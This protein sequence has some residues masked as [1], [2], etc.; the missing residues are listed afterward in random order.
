ML[1]PEVQQTTIT[2]ANGDARSLQGSI[3]GT[4][5]KKTLSLP[6]DVHQP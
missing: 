5:K 3:N 6:D 2:G 4:K 1:L